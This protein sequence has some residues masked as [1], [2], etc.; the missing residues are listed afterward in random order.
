MTSQG[1]LWFNKST[2]FS[3]LLKSLHVPNLYLAIIRDSGYKGVSWA[4]VNVPDWIEMCSHDILQFQFLIW[5]FGFFLAVHNSLPIYRKWL[6]AI[7]AIWGLITIQF[8]VLGQHFFF[9]PLFS[10]LASTKFIFK[11]FPDIFLC[12]I[13]KSFDFI[14]FINIK[15]IIISNFLK[16][17]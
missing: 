17:F 5:M 11:I 7:L 16:E 15:N 4:V 10:T 8:G 12:L 9:K 14:D 6:W 3:L 13:V 1:N 2:F